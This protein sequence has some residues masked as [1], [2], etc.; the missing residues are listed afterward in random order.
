MH[1]R[2]RRRCL[3]AAYQPLAPNLQFEVV[4]GGSVVGINALHDGTADIGM[5]SRHLAAEEAAGITAVQ[6]A[7]DVLVVIVHPSNPVAGLSRAQLRNLY[8][9]TITNWQT[10]GGPNLPVVLAR[11]QS[12]GSR[13]AVDELVL[14]KQRLTWV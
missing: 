9:G 12:S 6:I 13:G 10:L 14:A 2:V 3:V 5:S 11:E 7:S 1:S 8:L 4:A